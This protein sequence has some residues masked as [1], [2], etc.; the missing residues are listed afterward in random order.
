MWKNKGISEL[1]HVGT[2][3][4]VRRLELMRVIQLEPSTLCLYKTEIFRRPL[5]DKKLL[6]E[7]IRLFNENWLMNCN[8][9]GV[10]I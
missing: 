4:L 10:L 8:K 2:L 7:L 9:T 3:W 1:K 5:M 6:S